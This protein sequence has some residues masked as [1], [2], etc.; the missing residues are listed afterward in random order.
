MQE[1]HI[2]VKNQ[3]GMLKAVTEVLFGASINIEFIHAEP[4]ADAS[5][6]TEI[7]IKSNNDLSAVAESL[8][9]LDGVVDVK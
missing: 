2:I 4:M 8:K 1:L 3:A 9:A 5:G 6:N 7:V